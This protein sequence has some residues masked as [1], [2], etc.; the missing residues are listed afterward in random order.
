[1][2]LN[3]PIMYEKKGLPR[4]FYTGLGVGE[5]ISENYSVDLF[6]QQRYKKLKPLIQNPIAKYSLM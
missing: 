6:N 5:N 3:Q 4:N 2:K 1:M